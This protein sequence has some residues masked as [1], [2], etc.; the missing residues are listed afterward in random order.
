MAYKVRGH[1]VPKHR[2]TYLTVDWR[3]SFQTQNVQDNGYKGGYACKGVNLAN[4]YFG[5]RPQVSE[6]KNTQGMY[7]SVRTHID[8]R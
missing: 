6:K 1:E 8:H 7:Q 2:S 4:E 5:P 3:C